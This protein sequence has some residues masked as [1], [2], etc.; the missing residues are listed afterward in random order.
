MAKKRK[1]NR[2]RLYYSIG[3]VIIILLG[4]NSRHPALPRL[5]TAYAGDILWALMVYFLIALIFKTMLPVRVIMIAILFSFAIEIS[6]FY[7]AP[8]IDAFRQT[9]I[10]GLILGFG[11]LWSDLV[12]YLAGIAIGVL[13]D[14]FLAGSRFQKRSK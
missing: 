4:L 2:N 11:F 9:T 10:G 6:Q 7:H 1:Y 14:V 3:L 13:L 5:I 12:C 8:V